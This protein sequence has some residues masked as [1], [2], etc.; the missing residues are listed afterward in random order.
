MVQRVRSFSAFFAVL[1][2]VVVLAA[3]G[4]GSEEAA[5][6]ETV[7]I[8]ETE[9]ALDPSSVRIDE[10]GTVTFSVTNNGSMEHALEVEGQGVEEES[11]T[12]APGETAELTVD[13]TDG[14]YEIY[15][16]VDGHREQGMEGT[17][18]VGAGGGGAGT[19]TMEDEDEGSTTSGG[20]YGYGNG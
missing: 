13:L 5:T 3:C 2:A 10:A 12:I 18:T 6:G 9:F 11:D 15:C 8:G 1:A 7:S 17:L 4:S 19:G 20:G 16:P 14:S